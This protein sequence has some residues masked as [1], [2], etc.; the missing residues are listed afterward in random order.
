M[1][2]QGN[3][4]SPRPSDNDPAGSSAVTA[5]DRLLLDVSATFAAGL[6]AMDEG[7]DWPAPG[8]T[9]CLRKMVQA[10][11]DRAMSHEGLQEAVLNWSWQ[12]VSVRFGREQIDTAE[13]MMQRR[14]MRCFIAALDEAELPGRESL[15]ERIERDVPVMCGF[16]E[17][18]LRRFE[19]FLRLW[20]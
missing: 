4:G 9:R 5:T 12:Y 2:R 11:N 1:R 3:K 7:L 6:A 10:V 18:D 14:F 16:Q 17:V 8:T 19:P 15:V 13:P 20:D